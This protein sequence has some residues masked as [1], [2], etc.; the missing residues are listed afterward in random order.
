MASAEFKG[1]T[2]PVYETS[3]ADIET[4]LGFIKA[5]RFGKK[6]AVKS[7]YG[8]LMGRV[9]RNEES[10][11]F[12]TEDNTEITIIPLAISYLF[13]NLHRLRHAIYIS[14]DNADGITR[15]EH[16]AYLL[17]SDG[18]IFAN[19]D[20]RLQREEQKR[21]MEGESLDLVED[22]LPKF[23]LAD[24][25]H[26]EELLGIIRDEILPEVLATSKK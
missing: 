17:G 19:L 9:L 13:P 16:W 15:I 4:S 18:R 14:K 5:A 25:N 7:L 22:D 26:T 24:I 21:F 6:E 23:W 11:R 8:W 2:R 20:Y 3:L 12:R 1:T 10:R